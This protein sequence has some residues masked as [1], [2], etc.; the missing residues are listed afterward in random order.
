MWAAPPPISGTPP[1]RSR[2]SRAYAGTGSAFFPTPC[3]N[4]NADHSDYVSLLKKLRDIPGVKKVFI[5]S[6][7]RFDYLL[8]DRKREF[9]SELCRYHVSGQLKVAPE[10]VAAPVLALMGKPQ[11][12]VYEAF[13]EEF[14]K[15]NR[16]IGKS[17]TWSRI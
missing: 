13:T 7:I 14:R 10:H 12:S 2:W 17:S 9:L 3:R 8:A 11:H 4:L 5:R 16:K 1:V 6:G 15:M